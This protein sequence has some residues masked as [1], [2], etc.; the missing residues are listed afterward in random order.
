[1]IKFYV[2]I[3]RDPISLKEI[4][5]GKG[6]LKRAYSHLNGKSHNKVLKGRIEFYKEQNLTPFIELIECENEE[7]AY[8]LE[9]ELI[10]K[11]G[12]IDIN[13]GTLYNHTDGGRGGSRG[14]IQTKESNKKRSDSMKGKSSKWMKGKVQSEET[15]EK[16]RQSLLGKNKGKTSH[17]KGKKGIF[18]LSEE[19]K[20]KLRNSW[21]TRERV[22]IIC[23][24]CGKSF[25]QGF[26]KIHQNRYNL[27]D[28]K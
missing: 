22:K 19:T 20:Q 24:H 3:Y 21:K 26:L 9:Y 12:R 14:M 4:Y 25:N 5:V 2:Y 8:K 7:L 1:M 13:T 10:I 16:K 27:I 15:K 17:R 6:S 28:E 11:Y 23:S 18:H